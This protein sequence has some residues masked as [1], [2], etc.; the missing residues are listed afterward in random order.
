MAVKASL[1]PRRRRW[2]EPGRA[3]AQPPCPRLPA[4]PCLCPGR[5]GVCAHEGSCELSGSLYK[6]R[7][8]GGPLMESRRDQAPTCDEGLLQAASHPP[9]PLRTGSGPRGTRSCGE[10]QA[11]APLPRPLRQPPACC[12]PGGTDEHFLEGDPGDSASLW[13]VTITGTLS[14][15]PGHQ[16]GWLQHRDL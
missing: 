11:D 15:R 14:Y 8:R 7:T 6:D 16:V 10:S 4:D 9:R 5:G 2:K 13:D 1:F 12:G 3:G